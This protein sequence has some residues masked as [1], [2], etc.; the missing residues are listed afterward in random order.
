MKALWISLGGTLA[1]AILIYFALGWYHTFQEARRQLN[2]AVEDKDQ[3]QP[4][5]LQQRRLPRPVPLA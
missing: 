1:G 5:G 2:A 3:G 4:D